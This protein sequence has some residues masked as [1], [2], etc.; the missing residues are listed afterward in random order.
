MKK[1]DLARALQSRL[2][3]EP[4]PEPVKPEPPP[5]QE[6]KRRFHTSV[7]LNRKTYDQIKIGLLKEGDGRDFNRLVIDLL[8]T[9]YADAQDS[10]ELDDWQ[11]E[12]KR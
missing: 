12:E 5:S 4:T 3:P 11:D 10:Y 2:E 6:K 7:Y 9:W 1:N 8:K